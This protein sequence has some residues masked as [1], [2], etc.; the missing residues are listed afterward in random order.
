MKAGATTRCYRTLKSPRTACK[1]CTAK[2]QPHNRHAHKVSCKSRSIPGVDTKYRGVGGPWTVT[3]HRVAGC[4]NG[5]SPNFV[6]A[7]E[8][9]GVPAA[10]DYNGEDQIG[11]AIQQ[12]NSEQS[13]RGSLAY[14]YLRGPRCA[15]NGV[16]NE[17]GA[18]TPAIKRTNLTIVTMCHVT[19]VLFQGRRAV[20]IS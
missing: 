15:G 8:E 20:G 2:T 11:G 1:R 5:L 13:Q 3:D 10:K 4:L 17:P 7:L 9:Q 14:A 19:R 12:Y 6:A 16:T 18:S